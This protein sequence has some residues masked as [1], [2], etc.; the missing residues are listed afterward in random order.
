MHKHGVKLIAKSAYLEWIMRETMV[1]YARSV[2]H[3]ERC[4]FN[5]DS[6]ANTNLNVRKHFEAYINNFLS[7]RTTLGNHGGEP[8][9]SATLDGT[10]G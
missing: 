9:P 5:F 6:G 7:Q 3:D 4:V 10:L 8:L 1:V 2:E